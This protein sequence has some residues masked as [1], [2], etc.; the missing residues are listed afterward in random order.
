[1]YAGE[2]STR[3][4]V[5]IGASAS[6]R[7]M[8]KSVSLT[9]PSWAIKTLPGLTSRWVIPARCA[10]RRAAAVANPTTAAWA[11]VS[12]PCSEIRLA[13]LRD[14]TISRTTSGSPSTSTTS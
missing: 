8:P 5:V 6:L 11:V 7:A 12:F 10:A 4:A 14:G 13:R 9:W 2:P 1:M 3:P